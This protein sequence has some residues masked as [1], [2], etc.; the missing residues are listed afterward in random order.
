M[1]C[2]WRK[3][4]DQHTAIIKPWSPN[5]S[6][7]RAMLT[8]H[9]LY[10]DITSGQYL[11][12]GSGRSFVATW[13]VCLNAPCLSCA[14]HDACSIW[15]HW[16]RTDERTQP[17]NVLMS[18]TYA[19][20]VATNT[21]GLHDDQNSA[22]LSPVCLFPV[23]HCFRRSLQFLCNTKNPKVLKISRNP[24]QQLFSR[25]WSVADTRT[26]WTEK[27]KAQEAQLR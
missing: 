18:Q 21:L 6:C 3:N 17:I 25:F 23:F 7:S 13:P 8:L 15:N 27:T 5:L 1:S 24:I 14:W 9:N 26:V 10:I 22:E 12:Y 2:C 4:G 16:H 11:T 19:T 20:V